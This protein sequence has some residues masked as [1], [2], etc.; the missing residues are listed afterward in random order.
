MEHPLYDARKLT[1]DDLL[2]RIG[3]SRQYLNMQRRL[4][5]TEAANSIESVI[6]A[7]E[8]ESKRRIM[9]S[10]DLSAQKQKNKSNNPSDTIELGTISKDPDNEY[11][12]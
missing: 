8:A 11:P 3:K 4:G 10:N 2:D 12:W 6:T 7:L 9:L 5:H 1:D